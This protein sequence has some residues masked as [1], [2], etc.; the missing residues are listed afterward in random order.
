MVSYLQLT[1]DNYRHRSL[2]YAAAPEDISRLEPCLEDPAARV[3][4][5][6]LRGLVRADAARADQYLVAALNDA[7]AFVIRYALSLTSKQK[8]LLALED[9]KEAFEFAHS[10]ATRRQLSFASRLLGKWE[11][12]EFLLWLSIT[13]GLEIPGVGLD[14]W[15][16]A[17][18]RRFTSLGEHTRSRLLGQLHEVAG[19]MPD[20]RWSRIEMVLRRS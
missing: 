11:S 18:N 2:S 4:A 20:I 17:A 3:R 14:R 5:A 9:L 8:Q 15:L 19:R 7:S 1:Y 13:R 16:V 12:L 6:A 10:E